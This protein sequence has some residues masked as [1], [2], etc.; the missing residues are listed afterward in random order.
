MSHQDTGPGDPD[1]FVSLPWNLRVLGLERDEA[2]RLSSDIDGPFSTMYTTQKWKSGQIRSIKG[3]KKPSLGGARL[4][5]PGG[6]NF[7]E[8]PHPASVRL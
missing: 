3:R 8:M 4:S 5:K 1:W 6:V 7:T 2:G